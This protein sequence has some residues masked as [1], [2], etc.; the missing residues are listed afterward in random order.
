MGKNNGQKQWAKTMGKNKGQRQWEKEWEK[1]IKTSKFGGIVLDD[2]YVYGVGRNL[3]YEIM[4]KTGRT[5][6][7]CPIKMD[8]M[9]RKRESVSGNRA[10]PTDRTSAT[11]ENPINREVTMIIITNRM[12][13]VLFITV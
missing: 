10:V 6:I 5:I 8:K 3:A 13:N 7:P 12:V 2:D 4:K 9:V 1:A 11:P